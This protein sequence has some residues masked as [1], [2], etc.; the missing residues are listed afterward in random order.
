MDS[1]NTPRAT[2]LLRALS[3]SGSESLLV[4]QRGWKRWYPNTLSWVVKNTL[5]TSSVDAHHATGETGNVTS[6]NGEC[7]RLNPTY[8]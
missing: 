7:I 4:A 2:R 1:T 8:G 6:L 5:P 3:K